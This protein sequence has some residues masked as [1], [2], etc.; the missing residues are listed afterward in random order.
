[1]EMETLQTVAC[2][3][4][5]QV[6]AQEFH[7]FDLI[8]VGSHTHQ[9][10]VEMIRHQAVCRTKKFFPCACVQHEFPEVFVERYV[11][12]AGYCRDNSHAPVDDGKPLI[13]ES[14]EA[15]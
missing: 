3:Q 7:A 9:H 2:Q 6:F 5:V 15:R 10:H 12:P 1:M 4:P 11:E 14:V 13:R 8:G